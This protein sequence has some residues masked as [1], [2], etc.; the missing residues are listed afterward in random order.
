MVPKYRLRWICLLG[1]VHDIISSLASIQSP[2]RRYS[3]LLVGAQQCP[4]D[5]LG[6][7]HSLLP[8]SHCQ[9]FAMWGCP[10]LRGTCLGIP[11]IRI[12]L[13]WGLY[14]VPPILGN[15]HLGPPYWLACICGYFCRM[16]HEDP[17]HEQT[18]IQLSSRL[19]HKASHVL[20]GFRRGHGAAAAKC[21][22]P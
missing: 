20:P 11:I 21:C 12:P 8:P 3:C 18:R 16:I 4:C 2:K 7:S 5:K 1:I 10:K 13:F 17:P 22:A 19:L 9:C 15:Y 14:F 6:E